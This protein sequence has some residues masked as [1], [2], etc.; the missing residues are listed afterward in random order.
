MGFLLLPTTTFGQILEKDEAAFL[1]QRAPRL[2]AVIE[3][4][5]REQ[6]LEILEETSHWVETLREEWEEAR[7]DGEAW[8]E[9]MVGQM[10]NETAL[11][12]L[13]WKLEEGKIRKSA[14]ELQ[15]RILIE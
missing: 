15:L 5:Q 7:G 6:Y 1:R 9:L 8:A 3:E 4:A 11:E 10:A 12:F 14:M 13:T 2:L